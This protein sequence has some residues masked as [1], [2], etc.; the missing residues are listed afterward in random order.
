MISKKKGFPNIQPMSIPLYTVE[1]VRGLEEV[2]SLYTIS[3]F[4]SPIMSHPDTYD[5]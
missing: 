4:Q 1:Y 5:F 2:I 3:Y